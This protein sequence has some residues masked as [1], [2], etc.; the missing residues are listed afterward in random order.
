MHQRPGCATLILP[1]TNTSV[2]VRNMGVCHDPRASLR[3][4]RGCPRATSA[5]GEHAAET[6]VCARQVLNTAAAGWTLQLNDGYFFGLLERMTKGAPPPATS[7]R[8]AAMSCC[9]PAAVS[10]RA[11]GR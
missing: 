10:W 2:Y 1:K 6:G 9:R 7:H 4:M 8:S 11:A 5:G 3:P